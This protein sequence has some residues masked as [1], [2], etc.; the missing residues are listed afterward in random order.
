MSSW[1]YAPILFDTL[2]DAVGLKGAYWVLIV[3][4]C[5]PALL[6]VL[7]LSLI[8]FRCCDIVAG[9]L[10]SSSVASS[11]GV[12]LLAINSDNSLT[13]NPLHQSHQELGDASVDLPKE[14]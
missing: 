14:V 9:N 5:L 3:M 1:F 4:G 7:C 12:E 13:S 2:G 6:Y 11:V 10:I 8:E